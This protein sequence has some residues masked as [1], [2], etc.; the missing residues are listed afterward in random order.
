MTIWYTLSVIVLSLL[1]WPISDAVECESGADE[2]IPGTF[3]AAAVFTT[4]NI[5]TLGYGPCI[6]GTYGLFTM[7]TFQQYIGLILSVLALSVVVAKFQ[8]PKPDVVFG[9]KAIVTTRDG[10]PALMIRIGNRRVNLL[11][12]TRVK[13]TLLS[14]RK[15]A[16]G[17]TFVEHFPLEIDFPP[18]MTAVATAL[19]KIDHLSPKKI[20]WWF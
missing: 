10:V 9:K 19:H 17:E 15:T 3:G 18:N 12:S 5:I 20:D 13:V 16:E 7:G 8:I 4:S 14:S 1:T 6:P 11:Y 2:F